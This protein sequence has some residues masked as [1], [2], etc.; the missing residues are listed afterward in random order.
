MLVYG[1]PGVR[2]ESGVQ[3]PTHS[4]VCIRLSCRMDIKHPDQ[5]QSSIKGRAGVS[6]APGYGF[7]SHLCNFRYITSV[8]RELYIG[9]MCIWHPTAH[10]GL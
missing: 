7:E 3:F 9:G 5:S 6:Y 8:T 2:P 1:A 10:V 4:I